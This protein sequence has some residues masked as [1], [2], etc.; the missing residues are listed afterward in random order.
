MPS[1]RAIL[2]GSPALACSFRPLRPGL[3]CARS[4]SGSCAKQCEHDRRCPRRHGWIC[5][6][7]RVRLKCFLT[8][9]GSWLA[10]IML[11]RWPSG[12]TRS[13]SSIVRLSRPLMTSFAI[14][15]AYGLRLIRSTSDRSRRERRRQRM[16]RARRFV[17]SLINASI[18]IGVGVVSNTRAI[19]SFM[20]VRA[21]R[22]C[23]GRMVSI[24]TTARKLQLRR[25]S[26]CMRRRNRRK[27][28]RR[29]GRQLPSAFGAIK[30]SR[31]LSRTCRIVRA[32]P[33]SARM[34]R[35]SWARCSRRTMRWPATRWP[36]V[37]WRRTRE[38]RRTAVGSQMAAM[39]GP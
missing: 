32:C 11:R 1:T 35:W 20:S 17:A 27:E 34:T 15:S 26:R 28:R 2:W 23:K 29:K 33:L 30:R 13:N 38:R 18:I 37:R 24:M 36:P 22:R 39:R 14:S 8:A 4:S 12:T 3:R 16:T 7:V 19:A 25:C 31:G 9:H 10:L 5:C 6:P 21:H